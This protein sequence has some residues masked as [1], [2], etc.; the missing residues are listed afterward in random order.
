VQSS[1]S[2][3][4]STT[5]NVTSQATGRYLLIWITDLPPLASQSGRFETVINEVAVRG[6]TAGQPG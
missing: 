3:V 5:F 6:Y 2:A 1:A 4:N